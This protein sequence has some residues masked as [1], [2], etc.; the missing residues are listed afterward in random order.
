MRCKTG[1]WLATLSMAGWAMGA[2]AQSLE[3]TRNW[4]IRQSEMNPP[5]LRHYFEDGELVS[6]VSL[7]PGASSLGA[8][9]VLKAVELKQVTRITYVQ[10]AR[11]L[12]YSLFCDQPC[13]YLV[14]EPNRRS[15][16]FLFELYRQV[17]DDYPPRMSKA[18]QQLVKLHGGRTVPVTREP[19]AREAF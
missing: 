6:E 19:A 17:G 12:S 10:T 14:D 1:G 3:E 15:T 7:G 8:P 11:Y 9:P 16:K 2:Q 13:A 4:I 18:L 5:H